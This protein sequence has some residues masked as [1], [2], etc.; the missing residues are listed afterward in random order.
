MIPKPGK[1][2]TCSDNY[3]PI[4][5]APKL[6]KVLEWCILLIYGDS[7]STSSLQFGFKPGMSADM[8]TGLIKTVISR[9]CFNGSN[10]FGCFLDASKAFDRVSHLK[11]FSKLLEKNLPPIIIRLLFSWYRDQKF[12]VFWNKSLS[13]DF[14]VSKGVRQ[15]GV[16]SPIL[17]IVYID[18]LLTR[19]ESQGVGCYWSHYFAGAFGYADDIVLLSPSASA[20]R[21]MFN[22]CCQFAKDYNLIFNPD[23]TQLVRFSLHCP[24]ITSMSPT[25]LFAGHSLKLVDRACH[26]GHILRSDLSDNDD[27]LRVQTDMCRRANC[28]LSTFYAANPVLKTF[29]FR[30]FCLFLYGS[31]LWCLSSSGLRSLEVAFNNILRKIWNLPRHCHTNILHCLSRLDSLYN[32]IIHRSRMLC[33][34][35]RATGISIIC[36]IFE[37]SR[38]LSYTT[39]GYNSLNCNKYKRIYTDDV[40]LC[41]NFI[42]DVKLFPQENRNLFHEVYYMSTC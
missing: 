28:L 37:E 29:L 19:L 9:Y 11:L 16:L 4:A 7:F 6:S 38:R 23:K 12:S 42:R 33:K 24:V 5:L 17:F 14:S 13:K 10:V 21:M 27:I 39:F 18:E 22:T 41:S 26:L 30:T 35:A 1:D 8:C 15:G 25:F 36:D 40:K 2:P 32:V 34:K 20:L 3:R 31:A